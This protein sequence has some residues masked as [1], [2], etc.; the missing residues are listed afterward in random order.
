MTDP[1]AK[2]RDKSKPP[3]M[4]K[5]EEPEEYVAFKG[6]DTVERLDIHSTKNPSHSP[7]YGQLLNVIY[8]R[9]KFTNFILH[10]QFV[11]VMVEGRNLRPVIQAIKKGRADFIQEF[12]PK[13]WAKPT[14]QNAPFIELIE[15]DVPKGSASKGKDK[16]VNQ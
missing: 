8:D 16:D 4:P 7:I 5:V 1:L 15:I 11:M 9:I 14:D 10:Y 13:Q 3:A 2:F 6:R 12:D